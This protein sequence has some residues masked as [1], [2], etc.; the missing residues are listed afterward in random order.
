MNKKIKRKEIELRKLENN[1]PKINH[2]L[3][4]IL[5]ILTGGFW[6]IVWALIGMTTDSQD[7]HYDKIMVLENDIEEVKKGL[8]DE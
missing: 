3:H 7:T 5:T 6:V 1:P 2:V 8:E 4:L